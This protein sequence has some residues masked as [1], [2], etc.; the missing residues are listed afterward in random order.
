MR[1]A[2]DRARALAA[3]GAAMLACAGCTHA[4]CGLTVWAIG[5]EA[6][7]LERMVPGFE[8]S[9]PGSSVCVQ[10]LAWSSAQARLLSAVAAGDPPDVAQ[11]GDTDIAMLVTLHALRPERH[12]ADDFFP[13]ALQVTRFDGVSYGVPWY[14]DTRLLFYRPDILRRAGFDR[15]AR[16]WNGW[17]KQ[18]RA[19]RRILGPGQYALL[20]PTNEYEFL[21]VLALQE[22]APMLRDG[23]R[24][25]NFTSTS[26][27]RALSFYKSLYQ[28]HLAP[29][30]DD[31]QLVNLWWEMARGDFVFYVSGPWNIGE[32]RRFLPPRDEDLWM[33]APMPG[34]DGPGV[35]I[36][37]GSDFVIF[38]ASRRAP[39]AR[40]F[41]RYM[42]A[43][44]QQ[45]RLYELTGDL[46]ARRGVWGLPPLA[47]D[48]KL[49][50]F[51][52]QLERVR[53]FEPIPEWDEI[54]D[55]M[56]RM[57]ARVTAGDAS[58]RGATA[59]F[60]RTVDSW[61]AKRREFLARSTFP[62]AMPPTGGPLRAKAQ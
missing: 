29:R 59:R 3:L 4:P 37:G 28:G 58:V 50:A 51:R 15:P 41:I 39:L 48:I 6:D 57:A 18:M 35:S 9:H 27:Q 49:R 52:S 54:M 60:D 24:Y 44:K 16:T 12:I 19:V 43:E 62:A 11:V 55:G 23:D 61:L 21:E 25:S 20:A 45:V 26:F 56:R 31:R 2:F 22:P 10:E 42:L 40:R 38:R 36:I 46:P 32:F 17:L 7:A 14:V 8:A 30:V 5:S 1:S 33:T 13:G 47:N 53:P 34:P